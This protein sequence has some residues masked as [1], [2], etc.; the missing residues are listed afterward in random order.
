MDSFATSIRNIKR[1]PDR[2][3]YLMSLALLLRRSAAATQRPVTASLGTCHPAACNQAR[4]KPRK[5]ADLGHQPLL[6]AHLGGPRMPGF[7]AQRRRTPYRD[8]VRLPSA[9]VPDTQC[10]ILAP[11][12][13]PA[14]CRDRISQAHAYRLCAPRAEPDREDSLPGATDKHIVLMRTK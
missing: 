10:P 8:P 14:P 3:K 12:P 1:P 4:P 2:S 9:R 5:S 11:I 13:P 7:R 6:T